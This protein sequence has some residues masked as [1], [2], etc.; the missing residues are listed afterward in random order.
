MSTLTNH[1]AVSGH[2]FQFDYASAN[3]GDADAVSF[4]STAYAE[5]WELFS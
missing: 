5:G 1:E 3:P 2:V 4:S